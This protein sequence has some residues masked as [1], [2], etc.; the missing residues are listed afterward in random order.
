MK[1]QSFGYPNIF[2]SPPSPSSPS[3]NTF[4]TSDT[5]PHPLNMYS[6][7]II[8][9]YRWSKV[10]TSLFFLII[11]TVCTLTL[12]VYGSGFIYRLYLAEIEKSITFLSKRNLLEFFS[13]KSK[14]L[15]NIQ[16]LGMNLVKK[17]MGA[18]D[19]LL[20][21]LSVHDSL[22]TPS[23]LLHKSE[24]ARDQSITDNKIN[25]EQEPIDNHNI[26]KNF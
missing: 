12:V 16:R 13:K 10:Y 8:Y 7:F 23:S 4:Q 11:L 9:L 6:D 14:S 18:L 19:N 21:N 15:K 26:S 17:G 2:T 25:D 5:Y 1:F 24:R 3:S 22:G 20:T